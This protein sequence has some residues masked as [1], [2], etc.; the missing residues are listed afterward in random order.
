M[1][2]RI[3]HLLITAILLFS[4][5][6]SAQVDR[7]IGRNQYRNPKAKVEKKDVVEQTVEYLTKE[8]KLD[9][10]Q[11]AAA[12]TIVEKERPAITALSED[13]R[14]TTVEL[15][16][17]ARNIYDRVYN[18]VLPLLSKEQA[19]KYTKLREESQALKN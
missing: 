3:S 5:A 14:A 7:R 9:D 16:D 4:A 12:R 11:K 15:K 8:L 13:K 18:G 2:F 1:K 17:R 6:A 19:E 10:F